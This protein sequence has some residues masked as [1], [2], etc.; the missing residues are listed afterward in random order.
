V[1]AGELKG[2]RAKLDYLNPQTNH[3]SIDDKG[4]VQD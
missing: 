2:P 1:R 4:K 3:F